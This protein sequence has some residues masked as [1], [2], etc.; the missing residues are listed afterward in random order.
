MYNPRIE[1]IKKLEDKLARIENALKT[2][3]YTNPKHITEDF[4]AFCDTKK[5]IQ[6]QQ[7][8]LLMES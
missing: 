7:S 4:A 1:R 5:E 8:Y 2:F 6:I 3:Q